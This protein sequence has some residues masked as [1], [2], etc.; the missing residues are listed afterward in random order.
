MVTLSPKSGG[1]EPHPVAFGAA[2]GPAVEEEDF[3]HALKGN[4]FSGGISEISEPSCHLQFT[5]DPKRTKK[6]ESF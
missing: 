4:F 6:C 3:V 1:T 5:P 2:V